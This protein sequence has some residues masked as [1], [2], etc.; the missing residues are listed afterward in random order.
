[1]E[2][3]DRLRRLGE[4][5]L[6][7]DQSG[8]SLPELLTVMAV[9]PIVLAA[10]LL[11]TG[12][13]QLLAS[14]DTERSHTIREA[15]VGLDRITR[16]L[17]QAHTFIAVAPYRVEFVVRAAGLDKRVVHDCGD[18]D[19]SD[20]DLKRCVRYEVASDGTET[21]HQQ[22]IGRVVNQYPQGGVSPPAVFSYTPT[23]ADPRHVRV[24]VEVNARGARKEGYRYRVVLDD[25][26]HLR[27]RDLAN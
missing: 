2:L 24:K 5:R 14:N 15:Q 20:A 17:R 23:T 8:Y 19:P 21:P 9:L 7:R 16:E 11:F 1:M 26:V 25:G 6:V 27:N 4:T 13:A 10:V 22:L 18:P 12:K 3:R